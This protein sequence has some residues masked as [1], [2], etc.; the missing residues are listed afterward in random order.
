VSAA[1]LS[2]MVALVAHPAVGKV[3]EVRGDSVGQLQAVLVLDDSVEWVLHGLE[4]EDNE[5]L[6]RLAG[7]RIKLYGELNDPRIPTGNHV[8]VRRYDIVDVGKGVVPK[9]GRIAALQEG[10]LKL[11]FI[12]DD[13][14]AELLPDGWVEKMQKHVGAK[15]WIVGNKSGERFLPLRFSILRTGPKS[16]PAPEQIERE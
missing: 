7:T 6:V 5:E 14:T 8:L 2:I 4:L 15:V 10:K 16:A 1:I 11:L 9:I 3:T 12:A 13:G